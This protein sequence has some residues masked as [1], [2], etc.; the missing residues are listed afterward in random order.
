MWD[1]TLTPMEEATEAVHTGAWQRWRT[2]ASRQLLIKRWG[3]RG[4]SLISWRRE[5]RWS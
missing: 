5:L 1:E 4:T 3:P 2:T